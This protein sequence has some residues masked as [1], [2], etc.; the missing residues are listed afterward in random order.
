MK[1]LVYLFIGVSS[2]FLT[3]CLGHMQELNTDPET[4]G[5]TDPTA[6]FTGATLNFNNNSR[7]FLT[8]KYSGVMQLMQYVVSY[9]G[10]SDGIYANMAKQTW[11]Q[12]SN[13]TYG[14][15]YSTFGLQLNNL[16]EQVIPGKANPEEY[17]DI[18][19][20]ARILMAYEQWI[21]LDVYGAA[22]IEE[23][24]KLQSE[25]IRQ[26]A[27]DLYAS[28]YKTLD[29]KLKAAVAQ[30][31]SSNAVQKTLGANDFFYGGDV[32]KWIK[33]GNTLR[34]KMAQR[35]E[36]ADKAFYDQV[37]NEVT[38]NPANLI[39]SNAESCIY[40]HTNEY[41]NNTDDIQ[42]LTSRYCASRA[43]VDFLY[44]NNDPR[45]PILVRV[46]G[47]GNGNNNAL[48][49]GY[50]Q[51]A[52]TN[53][54]SGEDSATF[55]AKFPGFQRRYVGMS[56]NPDSAQSPYSRSHTIDIKYLNSNKVEA[57]MAIR[58]NS[59]IES[60]YYIKNGGIR[61]NNNMPATAIEDAAYYVDQNK[62][63]CQTPILTYAETCQMLAEIAIKKGSA[64]A[65]KD[66]TAWF[67]EGIK[68]SMEQYAT[69]ATQ[70]CVPSQMNETSDQYN[71]LTAA[72]IEA[73]L[74]QEQFATA[75]LEKIVSQQWVNLYLHP[76][77]MWA[78]WKRTSL[79]EFADVPSVTPG[80][81]NFETIAFGG[82]DLRIPRR[83]SLPTP[84]SANID[85]YNIAVEEL[86][87]DA[88]YGTSTD[89][90]FG[91]IFWDIP[92]K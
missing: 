89:Q 9:G 35:L 75:T 23:A 84:N 54:V 45:L 16:V 77:E 67:R 1:K 28:Y 55:V 73:Y 90:T 88:N 13:Q 36:K 46:N 17:N 12:P 2:M 79:P 87:K 57:Q 60:R 32:E 85:E 33:F 92:V 70:F 64:V 47:W 53:L 59:Q 62:I 91:R 80:V 51:T 49:D 25:G 14:S 29:A 76:E 78:T 19:A 65:G 7:A 81:A 42:D 30:I 21:I 39:A 5:T 3:S 86:K 4:I 11:P 37:I 63:Y 24:F 34:V 8:G 31:G 15:Y 56:A 20:I 61:G 6:V 58:I 74:A 68:A 83:Q 18:D 10:P 72:K 40:K 71:P 48:N 52:T 38:A 66:A 44:N 43:F 27:Y 26:P 69:L 41:N 82:A 50:F 22:P